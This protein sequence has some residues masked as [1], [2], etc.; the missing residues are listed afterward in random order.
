MFF[1]VPHWHFQTFYISSNSDKHKLLLRF[2]NKKLYQNSNIYRFLCTFGWSRTQYTLLRWAIYRSVWQPKLIRLA[3]FTNVRPDLPCQREK[4]QKICASSLLS[5]NDYDERLKGCARWSCVGFFT[6]GKTLIQK[7]FSSR[8]DLSK[9]CKTVR[10]AKN[11]L[12]MVLFSF[13]AAFFESYLFGVSGF[14]GL[15]FWFSLPL[16]LMYITKVKEISTT[17]QIVENSY[18]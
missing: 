1:W 2:F 9:N 18:K 8:V 3:L 5:F 10:I 15:I 16:A 11:T 6:E 13:L 4:L 7:D 17:K 12:F 14:E